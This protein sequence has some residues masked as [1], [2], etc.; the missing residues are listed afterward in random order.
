MKMIVGLGN[1]GSEY[2]GTRH[3]VGFSMI[4]NYAN[5][6]NIKSF[7]KKFSGSYAKVSHG[8]TTFIL[9]KP[10]LYMNLSG[11]VVRNFSQYFKIKPEDILVIQDDLDMPVGKIKIKF[12]GSS[13]GH[14]GIQN[15]IDNL[16]TSIFPRFKVG[17]DKDNLIPRNK[18]VLGKFRDDENEKLDKI[19]EF[20]NDII[21]DFVNYDIEK[22]MSKYNG[23]DHEIK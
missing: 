9:L 17:I 18:Y 16:N 6:Y 15:I 1:P 7:I 3:N 20:S 12:K 5:E 19:K 4:D 14:N 2:N 11:E 21:N 22:V 8:E 23:E 13:G 10:L